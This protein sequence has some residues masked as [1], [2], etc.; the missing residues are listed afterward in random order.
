VVEEQPKIKTFYLQLWK[1]RTNLVPS[2]PGNFVLLWLPYDAEGKINFTVSDAIPMSVSRWNEQIAELAITVKAVGPTTNE[3]HKYRL[4]MPLGLIGPRGNQFK[5]TGNKLL[6]IA[7][8]IGIVPLRFLAEVIRQSQPDTELYA[9]VGA[10]TK[11]ELIFIDELNTYCNK[12]YVLTDDGSYGIKGVATDYL[13]KLRNSVAI[14]QIFTCG[15]EPMM[16]KVLQFA[17]KYNIHAQFSLERYMHCGVGA[18]GFCSINS[19]LV[20]RDG[21]VFSADVLIREHVSTQK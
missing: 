3:L 10:K 14:D 5:V 12:L 8:G 16:E 6:I 17:V 15:P 21:P 1:Q 19:L 9:I 7:G 2:R 13:P 20:C 18:C 4:G 11:T